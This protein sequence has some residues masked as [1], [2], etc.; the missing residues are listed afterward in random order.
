MTHAAAVR[1]LH[2]SPHRGVFYITGGGAFLLADLLAAPGASATVL[3]AAVPYSP[4][5]LGALLGGTPERACC[6]PTARD[7]AMCAYMRARALN[8][9]E[10]GFGF[11]MTASLATLRPKRGEHRAH[12]ALQTA[13]ATHTWTLPLAKGARTRN[14][15][16]R[17]VADAALDA[18]AE[19]L[20]VQPVGPAAGSDTT[21]TH[22]AAHADAAL[23][24]LL[25]GERDAVGA[26][27]P[28]AIFPGAFSPLH[29][30]HRRIAALASARLDTPVTFEICIRNV[31]KPP[32]NFH[33]MLARR[34]Q[35]GQPAP[36]FT[37]AATF[38]EKA[39][40]FGP[41]VFVVGADTLARI[42]QAKYYPAG[43]LDSAIAE[44]A[45]LGCRF[46]VFGRMQAGR[47]VTLDDLALPAPLKALCDGVS[48]ADYRCDLSSTAL[49]ARGDSLAL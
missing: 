32:L 20:G 8:A 39:R 18:L 5:A 10:Q 27:R 16:E 7:L 47:F 31:D 42:A 29:E 6:A 1:A 26:G 33:D 36:W 9:G 22:E 15:E 23:Q 21:W 46:L 40:L 41:V 13:D 17:F 35:F 44:L 45:E 28:R 11:G 24:A 3:D 49:R 48:E 38:V 2:D 30:G 19:A 12:F 14:E 43:G 37:N 4:A 34:K 25:A